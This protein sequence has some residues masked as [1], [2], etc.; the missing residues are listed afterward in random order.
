MGCA[1][2]KPGQA[3]HAPH[4]HIYILAVG[5]A[6]P[7]P[8]QRHHLGHAPG[9][10]GKEEVHCDGQKAPLHAQII[11]SLP[12]IPGKAADALFP[13]V[14]LFPGIQIQKLKDIGVG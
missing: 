3:G 7:E 1:A 5:E 6:L 11:Q 10:R 4:Q 9:Q 2:H 14:V 13:G 8:G 12:E